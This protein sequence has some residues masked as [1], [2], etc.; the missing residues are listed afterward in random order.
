MLEFL[1]ADLLYELAQT[2]FFGM[3]LVIVDYLID[4]RKDLFIGKILSQHHSQSGLDSAASSYQ[5]LPSLGHS[6][7]A[8]IFYGR[9]GAG[10]CTSGYANFKL[11]GKLHA[12]IQLIQLQAHAHGILLASLAEGGSGADLDAPNA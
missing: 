6:D 3:V 9:L 10:V 5:K 1:E 12:M 11:P 8:D 2:L 7:Q 4:E